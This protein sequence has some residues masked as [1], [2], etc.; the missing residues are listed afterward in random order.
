MSGHAT[1]RGQASL[2]SLPKDAIHAVEE[3]VER[4]FLDRALNLVSDEAWARYKGQVHGP[5]VAVVEFASK[6]TDLLGWA[7]GEYVELLAKVA[8][9]SQILLPWSVVE[10]AAFS[11]VQR[12][13]KGTYERPWQGGFLMGAVFD[14]R[15]AA[16]FKSVHD[17]PWFRVPPD[18]WERSFFPEVRSG[19]WRNRAIE[20]AKQKIALL[21]HTTAPTET[22][23]SREDRRER[24]GGIPTW[25]ELKS[26]KSIF[27][28]EAARFLD[29]TDKTIRNRIRD[30]RLNRAESGRVSCDDKLFV[31]L[32]K[33]HGPAYR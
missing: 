21:A 28:W 15:K 26:K 2:E 33:K 23:V 31:E 11:F 20:G 32:R 3:M 27:Q 13:V 17:G 7:F 10:E 29:C 30:K 22:N 8:V 1:N 18:V 14:A 4:G 5:G 9:N 25:D 12:F 24:A 16:A 6:Y 19:S